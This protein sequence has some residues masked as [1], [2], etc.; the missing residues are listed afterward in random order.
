MRQKGQKIH[1]V[2]SRDAGATSSQF[3]RVKLI[4]IGTP[5]FGVPALQSLAGDPRFKVAA[6]VTNPDKPAGRGKTL[7]APPIK[8]AAATLGIKVLQPA[9]IREFAADLKKIAPDVIVVVAYSQIIPKEILELPKFGCINI[10][11]SLLPKYRGASVIQAPI[12]NGDRETGVS[13]MKMDETLDTGPVIH[14]SKVL[15]GPLETAATLYDKLSS[16]SG[17]IIAPVLFDYVAGKIKPVPQDE[18][19]ANYVG[20]LKKE[21]GLIDWNR[22][23]EELERFVRAMQPWPGAFSRVKETGQMLKINKVAP[24]RFEL[25]DQPIGKIF[26]YKNK[27]AVQTGRDALIIERLQPEGKKEMSADDFVRGHQNILGATLT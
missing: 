12:M 26:H 24:H 16:L 21:A 25:N 22:P 19:L 18:K 6:V 9:K 20:V 11:G 23:S 5:D 13:I 1:P 27:L 14:Q 8:R 7:T 4:F 15:I 2:K 17:E 10:H 3:N